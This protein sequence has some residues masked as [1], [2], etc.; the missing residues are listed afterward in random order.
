MGE[1]P[2]LASLVA[3]LTGRNPNV[4]YEVGIA[5]TVG[6]PVI[7]VTQDI[8]DVPFDLRAL[9]CVV[10]A[11]AS[12]RGGAILVKNLVNTLQAILKSE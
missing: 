8:D 7:M 5:H 6:K 9:R 11:A 2:P 10:Y 4:M 1:H 12:I 3:D